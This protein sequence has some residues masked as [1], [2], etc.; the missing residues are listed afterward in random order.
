[1]GY[2]FG[3]T[4]YILHELGNNLSD[5]FI[6]L[7]NENASFGNIINEDERIDREINKINEKSSKYRLLLDRN[8]ENIKE[9]IVCIDLLLEIEISFKTSFVMIIGD[10]INND[11]LVKVIDNETNGF[12]DTVKESDK[13]FYESI[14]EYLGYLC[15]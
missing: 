4:N 2:E 15:T 11:D 6:A 1:M 3:L 8:N 5:D 13:I 7:K 12:E 10:I 14:Y 9:I